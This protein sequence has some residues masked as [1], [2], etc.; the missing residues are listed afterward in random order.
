MLT[1]NIGV[2]D[3][4]TNGAMGTVSAVILT[5]N[6]RIHEVSWYSLE[7]YI[8]CIIRQAFNYCCSLLQV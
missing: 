6:K 3:G 1:T 7:Q 2:S 5:R 8:G 4:L